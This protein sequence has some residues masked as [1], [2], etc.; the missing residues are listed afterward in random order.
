MITPGSKIAVNLG[1]YLTDNVHDNEPE[2]NEGLIVKEEEVS[3]SSLQ[4]QL[5]KSR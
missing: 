4:E 2:K 5:P 3:E 1:G